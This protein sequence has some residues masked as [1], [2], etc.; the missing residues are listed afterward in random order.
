MRFSPQVLLSYR[1]ALFECPIGEE[2]KRVVSRGHETTPLLRED[3]ETGDGC[4]TAR[5]RTRGP[6]RALRR[7]ARP[8]PKPFRWNK[9]ARTTSSH[10]QNA[11]VSQ[12]WPSVIGME[13]LEQATKEPP[14]KSVG[15]LDQK[16][17]Q[18]HGLTF[19]HK[20]QRF[21]KR[22]FGS[23]SLCPLGKLLIKASLAVGVVQP[24]LSRVDG[25]PLE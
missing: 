5:T 12:R 8:G 16:R 2:H 11:S 18:E 13:L 17:K 9:S 10:P 25:S 6:D 19:V 4:A 24:P 14:I 1:T 3:Q 23:T 21:T 20:Y 15:G 7:N 22:I